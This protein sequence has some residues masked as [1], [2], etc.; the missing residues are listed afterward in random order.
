SINKNIEIGDSLSD[1]RTKMWRQNSNFKFVHVN[2]PQQK[3]PK[4]TDAVKQKEKVKK[5]YTFNPK[6][7]VPNLSPPKKSNYTIYTFGYGGVQ[8]TKEFLDILKRSGINCL[9]DIRINPHCGFNK[10]I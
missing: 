4:Q 5:H 9:V 10:V 8:T 3:S 1:L 2:T 6:K 7:F